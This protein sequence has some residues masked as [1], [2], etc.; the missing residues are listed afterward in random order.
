MEL[1]T[2]KDKDKVKQRLNSWNYQLLKKLQ[3]SKNFHILQLKLKRVDEYYDNI[4]NYAS[5]VLGIEDEERG[6]E[7]K[8]GIYLEDLPMS[9]FLNPSLL[10]HEVS[11]EEL[12]SLVSYTFNVGIIGAICV[13]SFDG[14][15]FL[16]MPCM[17]KYLSSHISLKDSLMHSGAK[18]YPSCYDFG[19]LDD[20]PLGDP[21]I[22]GFELDCA[23]FDIFAW[24]IFR[25]VY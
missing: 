19:M 17:A 5:C 4:A 9:P 20:T 25:K 3:R 16:L 23:L 1:K 10:F 2:M 22:V 24:R 7:K 8:L 12:K 6:K 15:V 21:K 13:I 14:N 11:F 18:F